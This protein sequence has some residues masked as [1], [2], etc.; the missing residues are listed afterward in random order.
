MGGC[1]AQVS[2]GLQVKRS[3]GLHLRGR[4]EWAVIKTEPIRM[5]VGFVIHTVKIATKWA[6]PRQPTAE[7]LSNLTCQL[8]DLFPWPWTVEHAQWALDN[9]HAI[10]G[11]KE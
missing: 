8:P 7:E 9:Q 4:L 3:I 11:G 10:V 2:R 6:E 5:T 1:E